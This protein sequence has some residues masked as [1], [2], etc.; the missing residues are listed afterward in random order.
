MWIHPLQSSSVQSFE[1][2]LHSS[3]KSLPHR[4]RLHDHPHPLLLHLHRR[5]SNLCGHPF[6]LV[7]LH[8]PVTNSTGSTSTKS[9]AMA[10]S[11]KASSWAQSSSCSPSSP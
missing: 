10:P 7:P 9:A 1:L 2:H 5:R 8:P 3:L 11:H 4:L 6:P